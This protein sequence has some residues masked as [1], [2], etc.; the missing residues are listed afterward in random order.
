MKCS[1]LLW[2]YKIE[3]LKYLTRIISEAEVIIMFKMLFY[4]NFMVFQILNLRNNVLIGFLSGTFLVFPEYIPDSTI[5]CS[6]RKRIIDNCKE[7]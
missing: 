3:S 4:S 1:F 2:D 7:E 6:F 5:V